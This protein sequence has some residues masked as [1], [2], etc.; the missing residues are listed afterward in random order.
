M[1]VCNF[2]FCTW[3]IRAT[4]YNSVASRKKR[5]S[6]CVGDSVNER[7]AVSAQLFVYPFARRRTQSNFVSNG[8]NFSPKKKQSTA[9][10]DTILHMMSKCQ[11]DRANC[12]Q[13]GKASVSV[14]VSNNT[15]PVTDCVSNADTAVVYCAHSRE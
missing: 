15:R 8:C 1:F 14:G 9:R 12:F 6:V 10:I 13:R 3:C 7:A 11:F 5:N 4:W 2:Y